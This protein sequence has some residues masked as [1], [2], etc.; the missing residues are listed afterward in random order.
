MTRDIAVLLDKQELTELNARWCRAVDR[1]DLELLLSCYHP[2]SRDNHGEFAGSGAEF[3]HNITQNRQTSGGSH[4]LLGSQL[5]E[6]VGDRATGEVY[7]DFHGVLAGSHRVYKS[8]GRYL[9]VYERRDG[10]W[11][12][13]E[14]TVVGEWRGEIQAVDTVLHGELGMDR[15]ALH[16]DDLV[17]RL[18]ASRV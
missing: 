3:A 13:L 12:I 16:P 7:Y 15:P 8:F 9:D 6:V 11:R 2:D 14:R 1:G 18:V 4:H 5:F 17:Y 10:E